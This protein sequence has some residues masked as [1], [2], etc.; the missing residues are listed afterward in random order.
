VP[1][2]STTSRQV[3]KAP[4]HALEA[5]LRDAHGVRRGET[6]AVGGEPEQEPALARGVAPQPA[7]Q[8]P[9][10]PGRRARRRR[11]RAELHAVALR[12]QQRD[13]VDADRRVRLDRERSALAA[14]DR[15]AYR[16]HGERDTGQC[17]REHAGEA[18]LVG[19]A[20]VGVERAAPRQQVEG[21]RMPDRRRLGELV[22]REQRDRLLGER[23]HARAAGARRRHDQRHHRASQPEAARERRQDARAGERRARRHGEQGGVERGRS[24]HAELD[25]ERHLGGRRQRTRAVDRGDLGV[26]QGARRGTRR[27]G[28]RAQEGE[29]GAAQR[30][31]IGLDRHDLAL[32]LDVGAER[33]VGG[34]RRELAQRQP[35]LVERGEQLRAERPGGTDDGDAHQRP[36]RSSAWST[37]SPIALHPSVSRCSPGKSR[38]A[39][40][41]PASSTA[42]TAARISSAA[43]C[44]PSECSS[45]SAADRIA[46]SGF[47]TSLPA[48]SGAEPCTGS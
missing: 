25:D 26:E 7:H 22:L 23:L 20:A 31:E 18:A 17:T 10:A 40:R 21:Q 48:M 13:L 29:I 30:R 27:L 6:R 32:E 47:A 11:R 14:E 41:W 39:E 37:R 38:S 28:R 19:A 34:D 44:A 3:G 1:S 5:R 33:A 24:R 43:A 12:E 8:H 36:P 46:A 9:L 2:Y 45:S 4:L 42:V 15:R 35:R 16:R